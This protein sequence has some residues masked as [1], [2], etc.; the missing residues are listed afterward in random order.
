MPRI[1]KKLT[2]DR[3]QCPTCGEFFNSSSAFDKHR[4]GPFGKASAPAQRRCMSPDEMRALGMVKNDAGFWIEKRMSDAQRQRL[5]DASK[6]AREATTA[7][8]RSR[9][10]VP[11]VPTYRSGPP[12][13]PRVARQAREK[14]RTEVKP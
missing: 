1:P 2:G 4:T 6:N 11:G 9:P 3:N 14:S 12:T 13:A 5:S 8:A 10:S 7:R